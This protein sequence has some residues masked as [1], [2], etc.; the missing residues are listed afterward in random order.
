MGR[1]SAIV[2]LSLTGLHFLFPSLQGPFL[3]FFFFFW[4]SFIWCFLKRASPINTWQRPV[5]HL[6]RKRIVFMTKRTKSSV[7]ITS[8]STQ[9]DG[10]DIIAQTVVFIFQLWKKRPSNKGQRWNNPSS[11]WILSERVYK[12]NDSLPLKR[13]T[14]MEPMSFR[15]PLYSSGLMSRQSKEKKKKLLA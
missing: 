5:P 4:S 1:A 2:F 9:E 14:D 11:F 3:F 15:T 12:E 13:S 10:I 8:E 7:Q 6:L